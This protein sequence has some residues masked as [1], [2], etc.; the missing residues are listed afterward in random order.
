MILIIV[1]EYFIV[2][3]S[4][5]SYYRLVEFSLE[6]IAVRPLPS[7]IADR[8]RNGKTTYLEAQLVHGQPRRSKT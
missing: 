4:P 6:E 5:V 7:R 2:K 1:A 8:G 3:L